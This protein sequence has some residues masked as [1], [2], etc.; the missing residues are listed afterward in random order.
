MQPIDAQPVRGLGGFSATVVS[1]SPVFVE[2]IETLARPL[3]LELASSAENRA[4][5]IDDAIIHDPNLVIVDAGVSE[6]VDL[7][8]LVSALTEALALHCVVVE[9]PS[10][11]PI[12]AELRA[13]PLARVV[14][15]PL[16]AAALSIALTAG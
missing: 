14:Q 11:D 16:S 15:R 1:A 10:G 8:D 3:G 12:P 2:E 5:A 4:R 7:T 6:T 9:S 13:S